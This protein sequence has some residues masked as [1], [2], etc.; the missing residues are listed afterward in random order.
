[1]NCV[2]E[3]F[4]EERQEPRNGV[5]NQRLQGGTEIK[6]TAWTSASEQWE[7]WPLDLGGAVTWRS[8]TRTDRAR[9]EGP[10]SAEE[11]GLA[12]KEGVSS[13]QKQVRSRLQ[14][15]WQKEPHLGRMI[16]GKHIPLRSLEGKGNFTPTPAMSKYLRVPL[17]K[18]NTFSPVLLIHMKNTNAI[19][20]SLQSNRIFHTVVK[21][22]KPANEL[23]SRAFPVCF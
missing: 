10:R 14:E 18:K 6:E 1:M 11:W 17:E 15:T 7:D 5:C 4:R 13:G 20:L 9:A 19:S 3:R 16:T 22:S 21:V 23:H 12:S 8:E 2:W